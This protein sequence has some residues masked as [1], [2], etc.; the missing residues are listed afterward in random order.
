M[1]YMDFMEA[2]TLHE[3]SNLTK[4]FFLRQ[5]LDFFLFWFVFSF[6][7]HGKK[8]KTNKKQ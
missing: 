3:N 8:E 4:D 1:G 5:P 6:F 2:Y 7:I